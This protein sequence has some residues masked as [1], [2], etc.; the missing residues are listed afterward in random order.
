MSLKHDYPELAA[1]VILRIEDT[2]GKT[3]EAASL[4]SKSGWIRFTDG[5]AVFISTL[6][7][8]AEVRIQEPWAWDLRMAGLI[9]EEREKEINEQSAAQNRAGLEKFDYQTFLRLKAKFEPEQEN[10]Q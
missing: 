10:P 2:V 4:T 9:T 5:T 7:D 6:G 1:K 8:E 3:V